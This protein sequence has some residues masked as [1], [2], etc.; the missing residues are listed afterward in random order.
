MFI[1]VLYWFNC[2]NKARLPY[3]ISLLDNAALKNDKVTNIFWKLIS[4]SQNKMKRIRVWSTM[5]KKNR[6][7]R[8]F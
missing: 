3:V 7:S 8:I 5:R 4:F 2:N 1:V 6:Y